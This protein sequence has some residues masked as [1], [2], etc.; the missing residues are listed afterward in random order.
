MEYKGHHITDKKIRKVFSGEPCYEYQVFE[1]NEYRTNKIPASDIIMLHNKM[2]EVERKY[3]E[4]G[5]EATITYFK[6]EQTYDRVGG[7][8]TLKYI[9]CYSRL[10]TDE[11]RDERVA[12]DKK[13]WDSVENDKKVK[14]EKALEEQRAK[15]KQEE[16]NAVEFLLARGYNVSKI[17]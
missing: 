13:Y 14:E 6:V 5:D 9:P 4:E 7:C 15:E 2:D 8:Y 17:E 10:E 12:S 3:W 1:S 11:E 16:K